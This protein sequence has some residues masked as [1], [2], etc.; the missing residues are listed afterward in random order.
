[1]T[2]CGRIWSHRDPHVPIPAVPKP[3]PSHPRH[4]GSATLPGSNARGEAPAKGNHIGRY[5]VLGSVGRGAMGVVLA[6]FDPELDRKIALKLLHSGSS[7]DG[8]A[9]LQREAQALARLSHPNVI[10]VHD[11]GT[12]QDQVF[13]A[14]ELVQG[15]TLD[16]WLQRRRPSWRT[17]V[18]MFI[19]AGEGL[20]AAHDAGMIHRDFKPANVLVSDDER[21]KVTDFGLARIDADPPAEPA[22]APDSGSGLDSSSSPTL[23]RT[24]SL[25]GTP[26]YMAPEQLMADQRTRARISSGFVWRSSKHW[27]GGARSTDP[28]D[29]SSRWPS[30]SSASS[31]RF[32]HGC[33]ADSSGRSAGV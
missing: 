20:A 27:R 31:C 19:R 12:H 25:M 22:A 3:D 5:V 2:R 8:R 1:M 28:P 24:G 33:P 4:D 7:S 21:V 29:G 18:E 32:P 15:T 13:I 14:M 9:R 23:T 10:R 16:M 30:S 6:A 11:V 26:A 17:V